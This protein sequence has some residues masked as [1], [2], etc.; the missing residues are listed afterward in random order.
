MNPLYEA[1][2]NTNYF[3]TGL[4]EPLRINQFSS[5]LDQLLGERQ[6]TTY[7][8]LTGWNPRSQWISEEENEVRN[9]ELQSELSQVVGTIVLPGVGRSADGKWEERSFLVLGITKEKAFYL[10]C[11]FEQ[12]AYLFGEKGGLVMLEWS[13]LLASGKSAKKC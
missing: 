2:L 6:K 10:A 12:T 3:V 13:V 5:E 4:S 11:K 8:Y 7:A 9:Q 1:Y